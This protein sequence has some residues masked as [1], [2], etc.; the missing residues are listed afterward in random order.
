MISWYAR[1]E[2]TARQRL[3]LAG[4]ME[5]LVPGLKPV[6][7]RASCCIIEKAPS[8]YPYIGP[9]AE[10]TSF[11]VVVGGNGH[12]ARGSDEIGRLAAT[13]VLGRRW[14]SPIPRETFTPVGQSPRVGLR[15]V[16]LEGCL[17]GNDDAEGTHFLASYPTCPRISRTRRNAFPRDATWCV[18]VSVY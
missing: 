15:L 2:L 3:F 6:S 17:L 5:M 12:G 8:R 13:V 7:V 9:L 10:D 18:P 11:T 1:Q 16:D 4:M 14:G